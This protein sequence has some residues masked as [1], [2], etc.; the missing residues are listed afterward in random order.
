MTRPFTESTVEEAALDWFSDLGYTVLYGPEIAPGER[1]EE[2]KTVTDVVLLG[3][4]TD[5]VNRLNPGI[6][7][8]VREDA[9]R[10]VL[11]LDSPSPIQNNRRFHAYLTDGVPV[12]YTRA[13]GS[14]GG[15]IVHLIDPAHPE[16]NDWAAV[17][18]YTIKEPYKQERRPDIVV[19]VNGLP[20]GLIELKSQKDETATIKKAFSQF[21]TYKEDIPSLFHY[22]EVLVISDG[23]EART[24]T[25]TAGW[26]WFTA[27]KTVDGE[28]L[29]PTSAS[30]LEVLIKGMFE[31]AH[32]LDL[33]L[34]F[35]VFEDDGVKISKKMAAYHQYHAVNKALDAT[36]AATAVKGNKRA[37]VVWHT[38][39]SGKSLT[40]TFYAGKVIRHP[41]MANP[42]LIVL[43]DRDDLDQQLFGTFALCR[44]LLRQSPQQ[45][46]NRAHLRDLLRVTSGGVIFTT[47]QKFRPDDGDT[48]PLLSD[49]RNIV[50][51][52]DE[53]HR[54][55]YGFGAKVIKGKGE[56]AGEEHLAYGYA[57]YLRD[58]LPNASFIGFTGTPVEATDKSTR[59][60]FGDYIDTYDIQRA[61]E[62]KATVP[63]YYEARLAKIALDANERPTID[64]DFEEVTEGE[65]T[66]GK[67]KIKSKWA[68]IEAVVGAQKRIDLI[69][70]DIVTHFEQ[71]QEALNG[72]GIIV[73]MSR[74][75]CVDLY[76]AIAALRPA[77]VSDEDDAGELKVI[78]T[79]SAADGPSWQPHIRN[80]VRRDALAK[81][82]KDENDHFKLVIVRDMW[83]TGF[84][85]PSLHTMY[86]DK[87]M[88]GLGLMQ[89]IARV[90][91]VWRDKDGGLI[92]DYLGLG[93][94]LKEALKSYTEADQRETGIPQEQA[95]TVMQEKYEVVRDMLYGFDY[96]VFFTGTA[97]ERVRVIPAAMDYLIDKDR[98]DGRKR[99]VDAVAGLSRAFAL[100]VP[101]TEALAVR[102][103][104]GLFQAIR[105]AMLKVTVEGRQ[106]RED[107]DTAVRQIVS[108]AVTSTEVMDIYAAVG[109][110]KPDASSILSD[111]F[112]EEVRGLPYKNVAFEA[113]ARLLNEEIRTRNRTNIIQSRLFSDKLEESI[114]RYQ[115]KALSAAE[116]M[117][118]LI[119]LAK[120]VREAAKRGEKL[121]LSDDE[122]AF[123]DALGVN[124]SAICVLGDDTLKLIAR[125]LVKTV[126][127]NVSIDWT[128]KENVKARLRV[129]VR[130]L[131]IKYDYPPDKTLAAVQT[132]LEQAEVLGKD[133]AA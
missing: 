87:P 35:V 120:E 117:T 6:P 119:N 21:E 118:E 17:N 48:Y 26:E 123:Y 93:T 28:T 80:K 108:R 112:L 36:V 65:E 79:G 116:I 18:Q 109:L 2:R 50:F 78:M 34:N 70:Q 40:M 76:N 66:E 126:R 55:Q 133:W 121:G 114:R 4:L 56:T 13:D 75:I 86:I 7:A 59:A 94:E 23:T 49:R 73:A 42:T 58:G 83:L 25:M 102:D 38:Q 14:I 30:Q 71:R 24:G 51:I 41:D 16:N 60:V 47:I 97:A 46:E 101:S 98:K 103:E 77:W 127:D 20:L 110:A 22:N 52:A 90:N 69:A 131:L 130:R 44:D 1:F 9:V 61:V 62:D 27:W 29:A 53:A 128:L 95:V 104:I 81:R 111:A 124:D 129:I 68:R 96:R 84:D 113:L 57:K 91:R 63:I 82:F 92:V 3:R 85:A 107:I 45:A 39:G 37:G 5:A 54:S 122:L 125:D 132:I 33:F 67:E 15:A 74:R 99:F 89:A 19:F 115:N 12:E 32:F 10:K 105:A 8:A 64:P 100:A 106:P 43:T 88:K 11:R 72:K 31:H